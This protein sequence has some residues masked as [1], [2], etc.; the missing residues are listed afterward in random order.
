[1]AQSVCAKEVNG[2]V[3]RGHVIKVGALWDDMVPI[4]NKFKKYRK[5]YKVTYSDP[6]NPIP[7]NVLSSKASYQIDNKKFY[8]IFARTTDPGPFRIV[9]IVTE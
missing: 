2:I 6:S 7:G 9:K 1:M 5:N 3:I 4:M 8:I